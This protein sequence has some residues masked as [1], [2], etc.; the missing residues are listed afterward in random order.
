ME[1]HGSQQLHRQR[2]LHVLRHHAHA[3]IPSYPLYVGGTLAI[4]GGYA[5]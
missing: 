2:R 4:M 5:E 3:S 1:V